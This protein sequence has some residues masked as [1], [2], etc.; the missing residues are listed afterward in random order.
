[1]RRHWDFL[2][3]LL[4]GKLLSSF[5]SA[6]L[7]NWEFFP[8]LPNSNVLI[9]KIPCGA[10]MFIRLYILTRIY[11]SSI[12]TNIKITLIFLCLITL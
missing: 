8:S 11:L 3:Y 4:I 10:L 7:T 6:G 1:M 2:T 5:S 9:G 12:I